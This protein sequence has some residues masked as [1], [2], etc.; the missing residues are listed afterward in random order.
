MNPTVCGIL[1]LTLLLSIVHLRLFI[2]SYV[3]VVRLFLLLC[4]SMEV[5]QFVQL[6][7]N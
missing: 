7:L 2:L 1:S 4:S 3:A 6:L 5:P